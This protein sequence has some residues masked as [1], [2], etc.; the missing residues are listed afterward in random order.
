MRVLIDNN[1]IHIAYALYK[2]W[3][4]MDTHTQE[5]QHNV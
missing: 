1:M 2:H 5:L 3:H 4:E